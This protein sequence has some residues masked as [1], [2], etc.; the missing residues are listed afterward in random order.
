MDFFREFT[1][2]VNRDDF[3]GM[4]SVYERTWEEKDSDLKELQTVMSREL[5]KRCPLPG[6]HRIRE[7]VY[8]FITGTCPDQ[9]GPDHILAA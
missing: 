8:C 5:I 1:D 3:D 6:R 9:A 2:A 4:L 7:N